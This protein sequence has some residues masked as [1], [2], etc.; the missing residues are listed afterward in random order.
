MKSQKSFLSLWPIVAFSCPVVRASEC[1]LSLPV[2]NK[3][4]TEGPTGENKKES[5]GSVF[6]HKSNKSTTGYQNLRSS[7]YDVSEELV[8]TSYAGSCCYIHH[9]SVKAGL[10]IELTQPAHSRPI[11][12]HNRT[13]GSQYDI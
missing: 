6:L 9:K 5:F 2:T 12:L 4:H 13:N 3:L 1:V 7:N 11:S 8:M 10:C